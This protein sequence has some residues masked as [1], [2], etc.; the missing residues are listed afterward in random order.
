MQLMKFGCAWF[1]EAGICA[2]STVCIWRGSNYRF[3]SFVLPFPLTAFEQKRVHWR[4]FDPKWK[5]QCLPS[6]SKCEDFIR[7]HISF[8]SFFLFFV[9]CILCWFMAAIKP[10]KWSATNFIFCQKLSGMQIIFFVW[11]WPWIVQLCLS[12]IRNQTLTHMSTASA[13][14]QCVGDSEPICDR[15]S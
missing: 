1:A 15:G 12:H 4:G 10:I 3:F 8:F 5:L 11:K 6:V 9:I 7:W 13:I 14:S 2:M